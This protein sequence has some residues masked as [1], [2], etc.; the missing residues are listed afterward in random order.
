MGFSSLE[1]SEFFCFPLLICLK[2]MLKL[3]QQ[4]GL[5]LELCYTGII[6]IIQ[7]SR[8]LNSAVK[9]RHFKVSVVARLASFEH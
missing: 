9:H 5:F 7:Y 2:G 6:C 4:T 3:L 1:V 8:M